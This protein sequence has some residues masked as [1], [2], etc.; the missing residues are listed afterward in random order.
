MIDFDV[1]IHADRLV[2]IR[3]IPKSELRQA[4]KCEILVPTRIPLDL[5]RNID[6][7]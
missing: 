6:N 3:E 2:Q 1:P 5:I 4:E 7:G